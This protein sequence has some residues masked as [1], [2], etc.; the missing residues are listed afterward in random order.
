VI[1]SEDPRRTIIVLVEPPLPFGKAAAR[2]YYVLV[3]GLVERENRV[4]TFATTRDPED[5]AAVMDLFAPSQYDL[6]LYPH[7]ERRGW[8]VNKLESTRRPYSYMFAPE[9]K[10]DLNRE[11]EAGFD[12]LHLEQL[13]SGWLGW[14]YAPK[15][16]LALHYLFR[17]DLAAAPPKTLSERLRRIATER[18]ERRILTHYPYIATLTPRLT[19]SVQNL[20][21]DSSVATVPLGLDASLY[22]FDAEPKVNGA[23]LGL[24]GSFDWEPTFS[25]AVRLLERL[26][27]EIKR[28]VPAA[29]LSIVGRHARKSLRAYLNEPD[30]TILENVPDIVPHFKALDILLYAPGEGSG[31]KVK[32]LEAFAFG[33]PVV[34]NQHGIEGLPVEDGVHAAVAEGDLDLVTRAS[35]L[36]LDADRRKRYRIAARRL[37]EECTDPESILDKLE[38][39]HS[40][41]ALRKE[42]GT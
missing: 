8:L 2:W 11:L 38:A 18:A 20:A 5:A 29:K 15:A 24:I 26:W 33:V 36:L 3:K 1:E 27:P 28:R 32:I 25:A 30:V 13:W 14:N 35:E 16:L 23:T 21:P 37:L 22:Q 40:A 12:V 39:V 42:I 7:P 31:V 41:I 10:K 4:T 19:Q 9:L 17:I 34:T 6:R